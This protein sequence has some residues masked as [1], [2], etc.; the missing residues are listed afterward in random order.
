MISMKF[1]YDTAAALKVGLARQ[2]EVTVTL[3]DEH[4][5]GL[6][7]A[8]RDALAI[9]MT[10]NARPSIAL[11]HGTP[12]E[13]IGIVRERVAQ[14]AADAADATAALDAL[15]AGILADEEDLLHKPGSNWRIRGWSDGAVVPWGD[16]RLAGLHTRLQAICDERN[17][18]IR[19]EEEAAEDRARMRAEVAER[20]KVAAQAARLADAHAWIEAYGTPRLRRIV[21]EGLLE[22]SMR[23]YRDER[24]DVERPGWTWINEGRD[25]G[26]E[27]LDPRNPSEEAF[28]ILDR[29]RVL[30]P[31]AALVRLRWTR[32]DPDGYEPD[33]VEH[34]W[35]AT[36]TFLGRAIMLVGE[37]Q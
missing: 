36:A 11:I 34:A 17:L 2:G 35:G 10:G 1:H 31:D 7:P 18:G 9:V 21:T 6:T 22:E 30:V 13:L 14:Q 20:A 26:S 29:A 15:I 23:T 19:I 33:R 12:E 25:K 28:Q 37:V 5:S 3:A 8:E 32:Q 24:L 16:E 4:V 27:H